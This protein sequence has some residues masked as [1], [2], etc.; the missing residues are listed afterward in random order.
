VRDLVEYAGQRNV[1]II[2]EIEMPGHCMAALAAYPDHGCSGGPYNIGVSGGIFDGI[3]CPG[4]EATFEFV[5][6][7][8]EE[9]TR[10]FLDKY[11]HIGGDE[12]DKENWK[13]CARCQARI[14]SEGL[15][16]EQGLQTYL[17]GAWQSCSKLVD[18]L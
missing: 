4:Q 10:L 12:V 13:K 15:K 6:D 18:A 8:L 1:E 3:L 14:Q 7:I 9:V 16:N 11:V 17:F 5:D 2:P